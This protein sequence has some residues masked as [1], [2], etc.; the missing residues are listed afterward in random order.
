MRTEAMLLFTSFSVWATYARKVEAVS[1]PKDAVCSGR[2]QADR[3]QEWQ[4]RRRSCVLGGCS[5]DF[6][7][8]GEAILWWWLIWYCWVKLFLWILKN[9]RLLNK[10]WQTSCDVF[11]ASCGSRTMDT[12][13]R[14]DVI[15]LVASYPT[16][17][18]AHNIFLP[19]KH[20]CTLLLQVVEFLR[21]PWNV[22]QVYPT[23]CK[24][25]KSALKVCV[26]VVFFWHSA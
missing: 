12:W 19:L 4:V 21:S 7:C 15:T 18:E 9:S 22:L 25:L 6:F 26:C 17:T 13:D 20:L 23:A 3:D 8:S 11:N 2:H 14:H 1:W 5:R 10:T 16:D 24:S